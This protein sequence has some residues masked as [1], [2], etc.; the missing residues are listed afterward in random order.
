MA[1]IYTATYDNLTLNKL[2]S[3]K[4]EEGDYEG[5]LSAI[6]R[7]QSNGENK[8]VLYQLY[9]TVYYKM[10]MYHEA[11]ESWYNYLSVCSP[12]K[13]V[14]AYNGLGASF[15]RLKD[16]NN[17][18]Y[19]FNLQVTS[20]SRQLYPYDDVVREFYNEVTD[21]KKAFYIAYPYK[22]A[23]FSKLIAYCYDLIKYNEYQDVIDNLKVVPKESKFYSEALMQTA[24]AHFFL[25]DN[26]K[27]VNCIEKSV[28]AD[29]NNATALCNA[30]SICKAVNER[31][32]ASFYIEKLRA[33]FPI[34]NEEARVKAVMVF[35]DFGDYKTAKTLALEQLKQKPYDVN[36]TYILAFLEFNLKNFE[37]AKQCFLK[38]YRLT[39]NYVSKS[40]ANY[41][42]SAIIKAKSNKRIKKL[43]FM[44]DLQHDAK[45]E[46]LQ[47][48]IELKNKKSFK[49]TD[50]FLS[51]CEYC[52]GSTNE[53][54]CFL[55]V[56][57]LFESNCQKSSEF[58]KK[59]LLSTSTYETVKK[60]IISC[61]ILDGYD[62]EL[63]VVFGAKFKKF[64][65]DKVVFYGDN[66]AVFQKAYAF[67]VSE[68]C[69]FCE[70]FSRL[71]DGAYEVYGALVFNG[72]ENEVD[73]EYALSALMFEVSKTIQEVN[74]TQLAKFFKSSTRAIK[75]VRDLYLSCINSGK[76]DG[77]N[78]QINESKED[79]T[80]TSD[81]LNYDYLYG[82]DDF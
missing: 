21:V 12:N 22:D 19:Y 16:L 47:K 9:A 31:E 48:L 39:K 71:K 37:G 4:V 58:L 32:K 40:Y 44:F 72:K 3:K 46:V 52:L 73:D 8:E 62:G 20:K 30:V 67:M 68:V 75:K 11:I 82:D 7:M 45:L 50:E 54:L 27:A 10:E 17:A 41:C 65:L 78:S 6:R 18:K 80:I 15:F 59:A 69:A 55:A 38:H 36:T 53:K 64:K 25:E 1:K 26:I 66:G 81:N 14:R 29:P 77:T 60:A 28:E 70:D 24:I 57:L 61:F 23:N 49:I 76:E 2:Y 34:K 56:D 5:A 74:K 63:S 79:K 42:D 33:S 51:L 13:C 35:E 43:E